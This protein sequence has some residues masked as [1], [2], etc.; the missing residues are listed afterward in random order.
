LK[1]KSV[2]FL[3][4]HFSKSGAF[5][6]DVV[7]GIHNSLVQP[8]RIT[9]SVA[10]E[11]TFDSNLSSEVYM[12]ERLESIAQSLEHRL[13]KHNISGKTITLKLNTVISHNKQ[14]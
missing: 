8:D 3:E 9:K 1:S 5:Y 6:Y 11:H 2:D 7:R 10:A 13:K 12:M 4:E 14:K